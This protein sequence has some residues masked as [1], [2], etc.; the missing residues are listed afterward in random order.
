[1]SAVLSMEMRDAIAA[2][3]G[4]RADG[5]TRERVIER[6]ARRA[7]ISFRAAKSLFYGESENPRSTTVESVRAALSRRTTNREDHARAAAERACAELSAV[8][9]NAILSGQDIDRDRFN[10]LL[11]G[12]AE[13]GA[14]VRP[15]APADQ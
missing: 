12:L 6:A 9:T 15:M 11:D 7:G 13:V 1:M 4:P 10:R 8:I 3:G 14:A 2:L 5:D